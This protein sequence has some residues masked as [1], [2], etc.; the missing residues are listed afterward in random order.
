MK[1][2]KRESRVVRAALAV[3]EEWENSL[4]DAQKHCQDGECQK[5]K[6]RAATYRRLLQRLDQRYRLT[7]PK[8]SVGGS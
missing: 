3:A 7:W 8:V 1:L 2:N 4:A 6:K 5:S